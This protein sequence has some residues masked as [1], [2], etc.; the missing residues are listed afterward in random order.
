[1]NAKT[2]SAMD[3]VELEKIRYIFPMITS[4][5][6]KNSTPIIPNLRLLLFSLMFVV[7]NVLYVAGQ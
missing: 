6:H 5:A 1:M 4:N 2:S 3:L 7:V